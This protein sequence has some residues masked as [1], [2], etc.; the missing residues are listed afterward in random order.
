MRLTLSGQHVG[1]AALLRIRIEDR[2][3]RRTPLRLPLQRVEGGPGHADVRAV[4]ET[5]KDQWRRAAVRFERL[6]RQVEVQPAESLSK[7]KA[8]AE[9][10]DERTLVDKRC[11]HVLSAVD[12]SGLHMRDEVKHLA[13]VVAQAR[14][15][16][17][18]EMEVA[19]AVVGE[20]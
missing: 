6:L 11:G 17:P 15:P 19:A 14:A 7:G 2:P 12:I 3:V 8:R 13:L 20:N 1:V 18:M 5:G 4:R 9:E 16:R 10:G